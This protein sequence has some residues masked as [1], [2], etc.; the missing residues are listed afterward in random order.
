MKKVLLIFALLLIFV[1]KNVYSQLI[2]NAETT[3]RPLT[4]I[5]F[6]SPTKGFIFGGDGASRQYISYKSTNA[7]ENWTVPLIQNITLGGVVGASFA[8]LC[9]VDSLYGWG[10]LN[11]SSIAR[12]TNGGLTWTTMNIGINFYRLNTIYFINRTTGWIGGQDVNYHN[13]IAKTTNGGLSWILLTQIL[14]FEPSQI[15]MLNESKGFLI[16]WA[17]LDTL[18]KTIDGGS[19]WDYFRASDS[20]SQPI[21]KIF[22]LDSFNGWLLGYN[23]WT[24]RTTNG[25]INWIFN[26]NNA[27]NTDDIYF[28][29][30][31]TGW[32]AE[33]SRIWIST[34]GGINW[35]IQ[36]NTSSTLGNYKS[37]YFKDTNVG[38]ATSDVGTVIKSTNGGSNWNSVIEPPYGTIFSIW[39]FDKNKGWAVG[40]YSDDGFVCKTNDGGFHWTSHTRYYNKY[41]N[42]ISFINANTGFVAATN[43][44]ILK[45]VNGGQNWD[46]LTIG[47]YS[48]NSI[49]FINLSSGWICGSSGQILKTTNAGSAWLNQI[50][51]TNYNLNA[52]QF[53]NETTGYIAGDSGKIFKTT[54]KGV[55]WIISQPI[56]NYSYNNLCF[57][58]N[59]TGWIIGNKRTGSGANWGTT[60][61]VIKTTN[62][63][64]NWTL[65]YSNYADFH[66]ITFMDIYFID[67][68]T[69]YLATRYY[70]ILKTT[71]GGSNWFSDIS[72]FPY[73]DYR[74]I[75][76]IDGSTGWIA[77]GYS[78]TGC[79]GTVLTTGNF[80]IGIKEIGTISEVFSLSQNY[81]NPFNPSTTIKYDIPKSSHVQI[82]IYDILGREVGQLLN[83]E[84][85]PGSY[86]ITWDGSGFASGVYF[87]KIMTNDF[88]ETKKMLML[89]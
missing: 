63:G 38:W 55:N 22:F 49:D 71:N 83:E 50:S 41:L 67:F 61:V 19:S 9:F 88:V 78:S 47:N 76:F 60:S 46:S 59:S 13:Q 2:W 29:N 45:T 34:N 24:S 12:T 58:N 68:Q 57:F 37:I 53:V 17:G 73:D 5:K 56:S 1:F 30:N 32:I 64:I 52:V 35:S 23:A 81:P 79:G 66:T 15:F 3:R 33:R 28:I 89:K 75:F 25:G 87:Y 4:L 16:G 62:E 85:K 72:P 42:A 77:G 74:S 44:C 27:W 26:R 11:N 40:N 48:Y 20:T 18:A 7:G 80:P 86:E 39:F 69:G 21:K 65:Q 54:N 51:G 43:G 70:G 84:K 10:C 82:V 36:L 6:I 8:N 31:N 14:K